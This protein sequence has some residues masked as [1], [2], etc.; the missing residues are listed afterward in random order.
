MSKKHKCDA[1]DKLSTI[2]YRL[3]DQ[4][5]GEFRLICGGKCTTKLMLENRAFCKQ[6]CNEFEM[7]L[8]EPVHDSD[9][10]RCINCK[11]GYFECYKY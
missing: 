10:K 8:F 1:C 7:P 6:N 11:Y 3:Y 9:E 4:T 2:F 5:I